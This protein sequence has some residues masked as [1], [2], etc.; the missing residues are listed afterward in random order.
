MT[1]RCASKWRCNA[2]GVLRVNGTLEE[3]P[4]KK[5]WT[6]SKLLWYI[7]KTQC[8]QT[9]PGQPRESGPSW[10]RFGFVRH[11]WSS[12]WSKVSPKTDLWVFVEEGQCSA[13]TR[14]MDQR[15]VVVRPG[16]ET[17]WPSPEKVHFVRARLPVNRVWFGHPVPRCQ[18]VHTGECAPSWVS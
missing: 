1:H 13:R 15:T 7:W 9:S 17:A 14:N 2:L 16:G 11:C 18:G 10:A 4:P 6:M 3:I 8:C 12:V 5:K